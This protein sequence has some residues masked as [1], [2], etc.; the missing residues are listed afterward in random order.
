MLKNK[1]NNAGYSHLNGHTVDRDSFT[2]AITLVM[3]TQ[4]ITALTIP[5]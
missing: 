5:N 1:E 3:S 2:S 4:S